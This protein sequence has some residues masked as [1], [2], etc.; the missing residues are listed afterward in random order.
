MGSLGGESGQWLRL[1]CDQRIG[2]R[3][4]RRDLGLKGSAPRTRE[5]AGTAV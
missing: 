3:A 1:R 2:E 5:P 4:D